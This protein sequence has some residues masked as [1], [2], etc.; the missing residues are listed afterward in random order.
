M[1]VY[2]EDIGISGLNY[3][4]LG[5]GLILASCLN[6]RFMDKIYI[7]FKNKNNDVGEPEYRLC[8]CY[9]SVS[10]LMI[11]FSNRQPVQHL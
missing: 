8:K 3:I 5:I 2:R 7:H 6:A 9:L 1:N 4:A 10:H 11:N